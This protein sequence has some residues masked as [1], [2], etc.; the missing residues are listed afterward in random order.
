MLCT[1]V[2]AAGN[3]ANTVLLLHCN[4]ADT[5]TTFTDDSIGGNTT[6]G[7]AVGNAQIDTTVKKFG[8]GSMMLDGT[9]DHVDMADDANWNVAAG[10]FTIDFWVNFD[11]NGASQ[12]FVTQQDSGTALHGMSKQN[13]SDSGIIGWEF[14]SSGWVLRGNYATT[15]AWNPTAGTWYHIAFVKTTGDV[16]IY[17]DGVSQA[18]TENTDIGVYSFQDLDGQLVIGADYQDQTELDGYIDEFRFSKG[19]ARWSAN[20]DVPTEEYSASPV[21]YLWF[22]CNETAANTTAVDAG[23]A[24]SNGTLAGGENFSTVGVTGKIG[25]GWEFDGNDYV[26]LSEQNGLFTGGE[27]TFMAWIKMADGQPAST[28][29]LFGGRNNAGADYMHRFFTT[30]AGALA[31]ANEDNGP[32]TY[33]E[34]AAGHFSDGVQDWFHVAWTGSD[35]DEQVLIYQDGELVALPVWDGDMNASGSTIAGITGQYAETPY[36]GAYNQDGSAV[37]ITSEI[38][39]D[40]VRIYKGKLTQEE[41]GWVYNGGDGTA[42]ALAD[43]PAPP[44]TSR[45]IIICTTS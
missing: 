9:D 10:D 7:T 45:R 29:G 13:G 8:T 42:L 35:T 17:I 31:G 41:I 25:G 34:S 19:I 27:F 26:T 33:W 15:A 11:E 44:S 38:I 24:S 1:P 16:A 5:S 18:V 21:E 20:F 43:L 40:D 2:W 12:V 3:D 14:W 39:F 28:H 23:T 36:I 22:D 30:A 32:S 37:T 4:G 6:N